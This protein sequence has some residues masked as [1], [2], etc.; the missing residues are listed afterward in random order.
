MT[1]TATAV[2][3]TDVV[4]SA[5]AAKGVAVSAAEATAKV[6]QEAHVAAAAAPEMEVALG[7]RVALEDC[8]GA[9]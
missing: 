2:E 9:P 6:A 3:V 5:G 1:A 7:H 4:E 8:Q